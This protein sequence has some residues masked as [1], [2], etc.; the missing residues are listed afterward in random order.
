MNQEP[1]QRAKEAER[2][3]SRDQAVIL[4]DAA[5]SN[6]TKLQMMIRS[7]EISIYGQG[8]Y[9]VNRVEEN[10]RQIRQDLSQVSKLLRL[11][12]K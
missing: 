2:N 1:Q 8:A 10:I 4:T 12:A 11:I 6:I 5:Q 9:S 3:A 7:C